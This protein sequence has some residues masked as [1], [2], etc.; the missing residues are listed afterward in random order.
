MVATPATEETVADSVPSTVY[1]PSPT[2]LPTLA[3]MPWWRD[4]AVRLMST[5]FEVSPHEL[6]PWLAP[7]SH[8]CQRM[9]WRTW[10]TVVL[11]L[12]CTWTR[13]R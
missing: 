4:R 5:S 2:P 6:E 3:D 11:M 10:K 9:C 1:V 8:L 13:L 7:L 12:S